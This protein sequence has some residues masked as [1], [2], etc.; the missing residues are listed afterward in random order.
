MKAHIPVLELIIVSPLQAG[1]RKFN[2]RRHQWVQRANKEGG[3]GVF[4]P[5]VTTRIE[6]RH[7]SAW[8]KRNRRQYTGAVGGEVLTGMWP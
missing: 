3:T 2:I 6:H 7:A 1:S 5:R 4:Q 8:L